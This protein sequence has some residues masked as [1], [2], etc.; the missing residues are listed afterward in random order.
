ME[1]LVSFLTHPFSHA[2]DLDDYS[3]RGFYLLGLL[4]VIITAALWSQGLFS[5]PLSQSNALL[6][7]FY[8]SLSDK[9]GIFNYIPDNLIPLATLPMLAWAALGTWKRGRHVVGEWTAN[10]FFLLLSKALSA[11]EWCI[12]HRWYSLFL[13]GVLSATIA[14]L[15]T[16]Q[17]QRLTH[18]QSLESDFV[19]WLEEVDRFIDSN[20]LARS[21]PVAYDKIHSAWHKDFVTILTRPDGTRH[22]ALCL[23]DMLDTLYLDR[24][25]MPWSAF[26]RLKDSELRRMANRCGGLSTSQKDRS[27]ARAYAL[28]DLL[29]ARA[30]VRLAEDVDEQPYTT[31]KELSDALTRFNEIGAIN[32]G[33]NDYS[34]RYRSDALNGAGTVYGNAMTAYMKTSPPLTPNQLSFVRSICNTP[35][36]CATRSLGAYEKAGESWDRCSFQGKRQRNNTTDL[37][38]RIAQ[39]YDRLSPSLTGRPFDAWMQTPAALAAQIEAHVRELM[40]CNFREPFFSTFAV[41]AAQGLATSANLRLRDGEDVRAEVAAAGRYLRLAYSF[42]PQNVSKWDVACFCFALR[43]ENLAPVLKDTVMSPADAL[44]DASKVLTVIARKCH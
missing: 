38:T 8:K 26:L 18:A 7:G 44:P 13:I 43:N 35:A 5:T 41:T 10:T 21:E 28:I 29:L 39:D 2:E 25:E 32:F 31:Y 11:G 33:A 20:P 27:S 22:P 24:S 1:W 16:L 37:L 42:E 30:D 3:Q 6:R 12:E 9:T 14:V 17:I 36:E 34:G 19:H 4:I 15:A 40:S 23:Q